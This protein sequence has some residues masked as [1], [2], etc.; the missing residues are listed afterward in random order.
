[1]ANAKLPVN[2]NLNSDEFEFSLEFSEIMEKS[3]AVILRDLKRALSKDQFKQLLY[4]CLTGIQILVRGPKIRRLES[5]YALSSLVPR[6]CRRIKAQ[7]SEYM[8]PDTCNFIGSTS[9]SSL[10]K[11]S[12]KISHNNLILKFSGMD[13]SVAVPLPCT[14]VCRL[15]II[16]NQHQVE[17][18]N[19]H[20]IK[21]AGTLPAKLPT[22]LTKIEKSLDNEKLGNSVLRTHFATLQEEWAKYEFI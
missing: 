8:D 16:L 7:T 21:W 20:I 22:L 2:L 5:L 17:N 4:S 19:S 1:M 13:T 6:A 12:T 3:T 18:T 14:S 9:S 10:S 15:D 11:V